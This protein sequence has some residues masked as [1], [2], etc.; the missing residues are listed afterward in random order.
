LTQNKVIQYI[1]ARVNGVTNGDKM[2][3]KEEHIIKKMSE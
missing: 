2:L 3:L 1:A